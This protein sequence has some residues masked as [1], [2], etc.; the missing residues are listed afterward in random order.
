M[1]FFIIN[2]QAQQQELDVICPCSIK[3]SLN[4]GALPLFNHSDKVTG[5]WLSVCT[6]LSGSWAQLHRQ[7]ESERDWERE[8]SAS[9]H[10]PQLSSIHASEPLSLV[11]TLH[12]LKNTSATN[13]CEQ[14]LRQCRNSWSLWK[15]VCPICS[16]QRLRTLCLLSATVQG[17]SSTSRGWLWTQH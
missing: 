6:S 9:S 12:R 17:S 5:D 16:T 11:S 8:H 1:F 13:V 14:I 15:E 10:P 4:T 7:R 2:R 3:T